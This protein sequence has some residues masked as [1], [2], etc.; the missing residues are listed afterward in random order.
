[1]TEKTETIEVEVPSVY[2]DMLAELEDEHGEDVVE[3]DIQ[4][5]VTDSLHE[6]YKQ[7]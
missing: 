6:S 5:I 1:M 4:S 2:A 3:S 7:L